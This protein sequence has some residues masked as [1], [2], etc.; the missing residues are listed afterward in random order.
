MRPGAFSIL[1]SKT[2]RPLRLAAG[3]EAGLNCGSKGRQPSSSAMQ[4]QVS[5]IQAKGDAV[6]GVLTTQRQHVHYLFYSAVESQ[7]DCFTLV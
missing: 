1:P 6:E 7:A 2:V 5:L 3:A 4:N